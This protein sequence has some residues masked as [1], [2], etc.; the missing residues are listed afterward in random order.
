MYDDRVRS[1]RQ[2][3][4]PSRETNTEV[5]KTAIHRLAARGWL[6]KEV[7]PIDLPC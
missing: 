3:P 6:Q 4:A 2:P 5:T 1:K 7:S